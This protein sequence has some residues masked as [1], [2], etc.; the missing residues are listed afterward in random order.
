M[1]T[2]L[3]KRPFAPS[4]HQAAFYT[5]MQTGRGSAILKAR[6]GSGKTTTVKRGLVHIPEGLSVQLFAFNHSAAKQLKEAIAEMASET[7]HPF[8][9]VR[10]GT[11]HSVGMGAVLKRLGL[12]FDKIEVTDKKMR[13][14]AR[15]MLGEYEYEIYGDFCVDLVGLAKGQGIGP[16]APD[17]EGA[18]HEIIAHHELFL[19]DATATEERAVEIARDMLR[20]SNRLAQRPADALSKPIID[21]D[22]QLYLPLLWRCRLWQNDWVFIDEA[23]DTNPVRRALAKLALK[24]GGRLVA[25]GDDRQAIYGFTG[26]SHDALDLIASEFRCTELPLTVSY[27]CPK[28]V[29]EKVR[30]L[31]PD[32]EVP[33]TAIQGEVKSCT[34]AEALDVLGPQDVI[35]CRQTAPL[36]NLCFVLIGRGRPAAVLGKNIGSNL[37]SLVNKQKA[38]GLDNLLAKLEA[39]RD[40]EVAKHMAKG[41][42]GKAESVTDRV[43]C[44]ITII[45]HLH[46]GERTV[47]GLVRKIEGM[48]TEGNDVLSLATIHKVKGREYRRVAILAPE[49]MPS[50]WARQEHQYQQEINLQYVGW[51]RTLE[52]LMEL[53]TATLPEAKKAKVEAV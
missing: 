47:P 38:K 28:A 5:W 12:D 15:S 51:T 30:A 22:D 17:L 19:D 42:E 21:F 10:A 53:T 6:A 3:A 20:E 1:N 31:V 49:L 44:V 46:E 18:W 32:F 34:L 40:R 48:F 25:V 33:D 50:K 36:V 23:Q 4:Q 52:V 29:A 13:N 26:A 24:P 27:R 41:E 39:Y 45:E 9:N 16:L 8:R 2:T 43:A 7:G 14:V 11:F 35:L 37:V